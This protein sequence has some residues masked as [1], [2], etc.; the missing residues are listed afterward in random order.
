MVKT[1]SGTGGKDAQ[2]QET[3]MEALTHVCDTMGRASVPGLSS[4]TG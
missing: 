1:G 2:L 3:A 4:G